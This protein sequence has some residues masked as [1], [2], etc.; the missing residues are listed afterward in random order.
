MAI[1][2]DVLLDR[3][4][5]LRE[6]LKEEERR[7]GVK[8]TVCTDRVLEEIAAKQPLKVSDF[9]A[10]SGIGRVFMEKYATRFLQVILSHKQ[11]SVKEVDVSRAAYKVLDHYKDRLTNISRRNPNLY[12]GRIVQQRNFDLALLGMD[13]ELVRFL[14]NKRVTT[15]DLT[16]PSSIEG[17]QLERAMTIL[18]RET[19]KDEKESGSYDLHIAYPYVEGIFKRDQFAVRAPLCYLPVKLVRD[20]R[21]FRLK[22]DPAKD[23]LF[24]RDLL[25]AATKFEQSD[26]DE[27]TP[28]LPALDPKTITEVVLPFYRQS[29]IDIQMKHVKM[30]FVP[31]ENVRKDVFSKRRK[32]VFE[33]VEQLTLGRYKL[34]SSMIQKDMSTIL[35]QQKYNDLLEG[36]IDESTLDQDE[37][38]VV[39]QLTHA[40][41]NETG[42]SYIN[43]L[44][45][46]QEKVIDLLNQEHKLVVWGPPGTGKSQTIT[47]LIAASVLKGHNVLVVSEKKVALDVIHS[48]LKN[49]AH[50]TM[51]IDDA[52]NKQAFYHKLQHILHPTP[53]VRTHNNN[54]YD[55][56]EQIDSI[57]FDL[58]RALELMYHESIQHVPIYRLYERYV[59]DR[60]I[61]TDLTPK[62]VHAMFQETFGSL[63]FEQIGEL[64]NTFDTNAH[65]RQY[66]DYGRM[67]D[68]HPLLA[69]IQTKIS[70]SNRLE[71]EA[72]DTEYQAYLESTRHAWWFR[73]RRLKKEFMNR[74]KD[75]LAFLFKR[76]SGVKAYLNELLKDPTLHTYVMQ[77]RNQLHKRKTKYDRL[78]N[79]ERTFLHMCDHHPFLKDR[80]DVA[81]DRGYLFDAFYTG[82]LE[83]HKAEHQEYLYVFDKY[84][85]K[86][87]ELSRLLEEKRLVT[88]ESFEMELYK[89]ALNLQNTKRIM[90]IKRHLESERKVSV[91]AFIDTFQ[92]ELMNAVRIWMMTPEVVSA[93]IPLVYGMF[94]VVIFD[95]AS[96]MF[97]EKGI[98]AIYR[99]K[100]VVI[101]GDTKQLR[102]SSLGIGRLQEDDEFYEDDVLTDVSLD[103]KS[104]LDLARYKYYETILNYHYRSRYEELIAFSNHAFYDGK[105]I[106]APNHVKGDGPPIEYV[107]VKDGVFENRKNEAEADTVIKL[108]K[109]IFR[110]RAHNE[111]IGVITFNSAQRDL[112]ENKI[113]E[114]L[115]K[116][117]KY[118]RLFEQ[119][120]FRTEDG[121]DKS[122]FVKNIENVQGDERDIIVFSMGYARDPFGQIH[123]RF[124]WL[125]NEGGQNRLNVAISRA[126]QKIY[127]ISSLHPEELKVEDLSSTGPKLLKEY[128]RYCHAVSRGDD[129]AAKD[130][131]GRL[132]ADRK[133][134]EN[135]AA[136]TLIQH[137][138]QRLE[139]SNYEVETEVGI[140]GYSVSLAVKNPDAE[141]YLL[142]ILCDVHDDLDMNARRDLFHQETYLK[143]RGWNLYR[144]FSANW[145]TD[146][147]REMRRI[148]ELL[149]A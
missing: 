69:R 99:A 123:R 118:Q 98:P 80:E 77:E 23:I 38:D 93:V 145:Y 103:A 95:E 47:S 92:V 127:F 21:H 34:Y 84:D 49:A 89:H 106:V 117:G 16:F 26:L 88:T 9:L 107:L 122:L 137:I 125:N 22:K 100:R 149:K 138:K 28:F 64:E 115:F 67:L 101:A 14:T 82:Y 4:V 56:E 6:E 140:G 105:L 12:M 53:P 13:L 20:K 2:P 24:N 42:L 8:A 33:G 96:Q 124:G 60:N 66:L 110:D 142:G 54:I 19:N 70:R 10:I 58:D 90:D 119:E 43:P 44:N 75:T 57:L 91:K 55:L 48:R 126:K 71:L 139:R 74:H 37:K 36:L 81:K 86:R 97:V 141:G 94:D 143:A 148:R 40:P 134:A 65:L 133:K 146:A 78:T 25:L 3:L 87:D 1:K 128:M 39:F 18:Y 109:K 27:K 116:R 73:R 135:G 63:T 30:A 120:L 111:T 15:L 102:P 11:Q 147:N 121:E 83:H 112:I 52:E 132:S 41:I 136:S 31:F 7:R 76:K 130:V 35:D 104:L 144:V 108:L 51:F 79:L 72:F 62:Q 45:Y 131:L 29:G 32:G 68:T 61:Q 50:Y 85:E 5:S 113:D 129:R 46:S 114:E 59:N 17:D